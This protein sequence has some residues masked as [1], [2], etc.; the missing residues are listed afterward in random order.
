MRD[1]SS[2]VT[3]RTFMPHGAHQP[4][5]ETRRV[6]TVS[7][8]CF[9]TVISIRLFV[10]VSPHRSLRPGSSRAFYCYPL[11]DALRFSLLSQEPRSTWLTSTCKVLLTPEKCP[12]QTL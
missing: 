9:S 4:T 5:A 3:I 6:P 1:A 7:T 10:I 8:R 2:A 11:G 12:L